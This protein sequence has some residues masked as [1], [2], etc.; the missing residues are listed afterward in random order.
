MPHPVVCGK[1]YV[2]ERQALLFKEKQIS[3]LSVKIPN[4][5]DDGSC[6][7]SSKYEREGEVGRETTH[8]HEGD[9]TGSSEMC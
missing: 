1:I 9:D 2:T 7:F 4:F 3:E 5:L 6:Y 8:R